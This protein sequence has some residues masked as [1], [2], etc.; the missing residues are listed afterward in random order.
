[1]ARNSSTTSTGRTPS[2]TT[3]KSGGTRTATRSGGKGKARDTTAAATPGVPAIQVGSGS[4]YAAAA[5]LSNA[6][7][8]DIKVSTPLGNA[9]AKGLDMMSLFA[10]DLT[11]GMQAMLGAGGNAND[12][13]GEGTVHD[14]PER[15]HLGMRRG[16]NGQV[17]YVT[18]YAAPRKIK[19]VPGSELMRRVQLSKDLARFLPTEVRHAYDTLQRLHATNRKGELAGQIKQAED[20]LMGVMDKAVLPIAEHVANGVPLTALPAEDLAIYFLAAVYAATKRQYEIM[21]ALP[22]IGAV[23]PETVYNTEHKAYMDYVMSQHASP[24]EP[25]ASTGGG[26]GAG[27]HVRQEQ[28]TGP[29]HPFDQTWYLE[30]LTMQEHQ[31][32]MDQ[33]GAPAWTLLDATLALASAVLLVTE[34]KLIAFGERPDEVGGGG[35]SVIKGILYLQTPTPLIYNTPN[36]VTNYDVLAGFINGQHALTQWSPALMGDVL[37]LAPDDYANLATQFLNSAGGTMSV[38][39][40]LLMN[41]AGLREIRQAREYTPNPQELQRLQD[42]SNPYADYYQGGV[43]VGNAQKRALTLH[44]DDPMVISR[45]T[46]FAMRTHDSGLSDGM[47]K[48]KQ[49]LSTGGVKLVQPLGFRA[50]YLNV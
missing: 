1:M 44:K 3:R 4:G 34:A 43:R 39:A 10:A 27:V 9:S 40:A 49:A 23:L 24:S 5:G 26:I 38:L 48:G 21:Y 50:A 16:R 7:R 22:T 30:E 37:T 33:D 2:R 32:F 31:E 35:P 17:E 45:V 19:G 14:N 12:I 13:A 28:R 11:A 15:P 29:L 46:G 20:D 47:Y 41:V 8:R 36:G 25:F 42:A 6:P 18:K